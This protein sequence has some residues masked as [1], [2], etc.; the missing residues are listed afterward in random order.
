VKITDLQVDGFG[1]WKGLTVESLSDEMTVFYGENEAGKTTL[2]QFI[3]S[4]MFGFSAD[5]I[6]RY[7]PP[8]Y[9]GLAGGSMDV[10][11]KTGP[12]EIQRH[13]DPNR[14]SDSIGDLAVTDAHDGSVHGRSF[15]SK[16]IS[17]IDEPIFNN[18]FAIGLREI[19]ELG[20]LNGTAAAEQLYRLTSG[21]DRVS[22]VDVMKD[23]RFRR[24]EIWST[25][26]EQTS[27]LEELS[28]RRQK[29]LREI[30]ELKQKSKRWS[31]LASDST[32]LA[33][34]IKDLDRE[35]S[36]KEKESRLVE[37]A[38]QISERWAARHYLNEQIKA[39]GVLPDERDISIPKLDEFNAKIAQIRERLGQIRLQ[40]KEIKKDALALP[41]NRALWLQK[42]RAEA[43]TEHLPWIESL[44]RQSDRL[45]TELTSLDNSLV[46]EVDGLGNQ[47]KIK[48]KDI[49]ELTGRRLH[50]LETTGRK[51]EEQQEKLRKFQ[52]EHEKVEFDL[53]QHQ[54]RLGNTIS[55]RGGSLDT[56]EEVTRYVN[57]LR[58]H[59]ELEE[60]I[61]KLNQN[62]HALER[63]IDVVVSEQV[64]PVGK[65]SVIGVI[66][67]LGVLLL[68]FGLLDSLSGG[69][70]LGDTSRTVTNASRNLGFLFMFLGM[71]AG[72]ISLGLKY[73][74]ERLAKDEL[75]DFRHQMELVRQQLRRCK[76]EREEIERQLPTPVTQYQVELKDAENRLALMEE[77]VPLENRVQ[78]TKSSSEDLRRRM[79]AQEREVELAKEH[80]RASLRTAGLPEALLPL[81]LKELTLRGE[82]I[83]GLNS[84][85]DQLQAEKVEKDKELAQIQTRIDDL[86]HD[87][88][89]A[90]KDANL[91]D[92]LNRLNRLISEQKA[93]VNSRKELV[94]K[95]R[96]LR[97][98]AT[99]TRVELE[100]YVGLRERLFAQVGVDTE[101][102]YRA[103][104][105][106]HRERRKLTEK[107]DAHTE[108][109][110]IALGKQFL[111]KQLQ[112]LMET[113]G[114]AG[115]EK[116][117]EAIQQEVEKLK[118]LQ[119]QLHQ[120]RGE[121]IQEVKM[122][123]EDSRM[124]VVR[125]ELNA[126]EQEFANEQ[127][128][129]QVLAASTQIF[130]VIRESYEAKRQPE[131]LKEASNYLGRLTDG[132]YVRIWTR[133]VGE[134]LLVDNAAS[135][136]LAVEKLSR[137]T[138]ET[139]FLSLRMA[140][141]SAY[142]RRGALIPLVLDDVLVNFDGHRAQ[143][144]AEVLVDFAKKGY[145]ILMFTCHGH[146]R[147]MFWK[148]GADVRIL[149]HHRDV[150]QEHAVP[151]V[152]EGPEPVSKPVVEISE[153]VSQSEV[154]L[155]RIPVEYVPA[156]VGLDVDDYDPDLEY[157][158]SAV[159]NDQQQEER[160]RNGL[161][162][163]SPR[164]GLPLDLSGN[165][166]FWRDQTRRR[167]EFSQA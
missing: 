101:E 82:K 136:S 140:L 41:I 58:R 141:V 1:V 144:A 18:V 107:R 127:K 111:E 142:A 90:T 145:Q 146:M 125:L 77:L 52:Q 131:T 70:L 13:V 72:A 129:W 4:M 109:I 30:D 133:L 110:T 48:A 46:G 63:D 5:R 74:W 2:M 12:F 38:I 156:N 123:G 80:W 161:V 86:F 163:I 121:F 34:Q 24:E 88:G 55:E 132:K 42:R 22:L 167:T 151:L 112:A 102:A 53:L 21:L 73:H 139:V 137:G 122:L 126:V 65:L 113:Y 85:R 124:D 159:V 117:W 97:S 130:E 14:L 95:Y 116:R 115:L 61:E 91:I 143:C 89:I 36:A 98:R 119:T 15:L 54:D 33:N 152:W 20:A 154:A 120:Q 94:S 7:T 68:G 56:I 47:L 147:D 69:D 31:R 81:Q 67:V 108:Q 9:G 128:E 157:E 8:V 153:P 66:F 23:L 59:L 32:D 50:D 83:S 43:I 49:R 103:L 93:L 45:Q 92:R 27:R 40:R 106:Q 134:E 166:D 149:P 104:E 19:Q 16:L 71:I 96:G 155:E 165:E 60:K 64:L 57:R 100:K 114:S 87:A 10:L 79:V 78:A 162:F 76:T 51:L 17:D 37:I 25:D 39:L 26:P 11:T 75:D 28:Q 135:E 138:R 44:Q 118:Q 29:L 164:Y 148:L 6:T 84:R 99:R 105:N 160:L 158:L 35:L 3:R 62:K 150:F